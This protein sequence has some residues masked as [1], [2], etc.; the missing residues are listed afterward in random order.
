MTVTDALKKAQELLSA[1]SIKVED[2]RKAGAAMELIT[3]CIKTLEGAAQKG[4]QT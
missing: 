2:A 3:S 4:D 1:C